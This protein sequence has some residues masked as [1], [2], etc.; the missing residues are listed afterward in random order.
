MSEV[1]EDSDVATSE[2]HSK[3]DT[4]L[5]NG[6]VKGHE[7]QISQVNGQATVYTN[8]HDAS[9]EEK[10][11]EKEKEK[12][13]ARAPLLS[14]GSSYK[15]EDTPTNAD[16]TILAALSENAKNVRREKKPSDGDSADYDT[17]SDSIETLEE[18]SSHEDT[19]NDLSDSQ[20]QMSLTN[21]DDE[22][23][24]VSETDIR[25]T[26]DD[27]PTLN[28]V[29]RPD[30]LSLPRPLQQVERVR[31][32]SEVQIKSVSCDPRG[33]PD[34]G[35]T[36]S[37]IIE[38]NS[39]LRRRD[40]LGSDEY[41]SKSLPHGTIMRKGEMIEFVAEDLQEKIRRSS[42]LSRTDSSC[43]SSRRSSLRSV[44]SST[45][46]STSMATSTASGMS[47][48]PSS[49]FQQSPDDIPP[50]DPQAV[51]ELENQA[52]LV[53]DSVDLMMGNLKANLHKMSSITIGCLDAYRRSVDVTCE[54][55]DG[56]IKSMYALMAKCEELSTNM[57]P[58]Y[59]LAEKIKEIKRLL[60]LFEAQLA[61][62][63]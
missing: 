25:E 16:T 41:L 30:S 48:S 45:S 56:S 52:H 28:G 58:V 6:V 31:S 61:D 49:L 60:D 20:R 12:E 63:T 38:I 7:K 15:S 46:V 40:G 11:K 35:R 22:S 18:E 42:P 13:R 50:I 59:K 2:T 32:R 39:S 36:Q 8:G 1:T 43:Y 47:R 14:Q 3:S 19:V 29:S 33:Q 37:E 44:S 62:K 53:A 23:D 4:H 10:H 51:L 27:Y 5:Q 55:V 21:H 24:E 26:T 57:Q 17:Q 54:S 34:R 9:P